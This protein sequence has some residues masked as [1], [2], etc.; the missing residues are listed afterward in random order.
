[1]VKKYCFNIL[2]QLEELEEL[3]ITELK[4]FIKELYEEKSSNRLSFVVF[5]SELQKSICVQVNRVKDINLIEEIN[6]TLSIDE[7]EWNSD[8]SLSL[9]YLFKED[10]DGEWWKEKKADT[11]WNSIIQ[12]GPYFYELMNPYIPL[13]AYV[14]VDGKE[15]H[16]EP[17]EERIVRFYVNRIISESKQKVTTKCTEDEY[18]NRNFFNDLQEYLLTKEHKIIFSY[19]NIKKIDWTPF[20]GLIEEEKIKNN[21]LSVLEKQRKEQIKLKTT[22][23]WVCY[24]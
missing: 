10:K 8:I 6:K 3:T 16:L 21:A 17:E 1:M 20:I 9:P 7:L 22:F 12:K 24:Y 15:I 18:F 19:E 13:G 11:K 23:L 4:D 14:I 5:F 2:T